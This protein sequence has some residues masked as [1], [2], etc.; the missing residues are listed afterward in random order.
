MREA[1]RIQ[2]E[3]GRGPLAGLAEVDLAAA[4]ERELLLLLAERGGGGGRR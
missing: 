3:T 2:Y 4:A 1:A